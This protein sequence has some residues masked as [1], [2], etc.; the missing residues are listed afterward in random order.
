MM[1]PID[2]HQPQRARFP[3]PLRGKMRRGSLSAI[4]M[5]S[6]PT[7]RPTSQPGG[8]RDL[9]GSWPQFRKG[10][11][12][13]CPELDAVGVPFKKFSL[14]RHADGLR[15]TTVDVTII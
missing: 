13:R 9:I 6:S 7:A 11:T 2:A 8:A 15:Q 4:A 14:D 5:R 12:S 3:S 1:P 10:R